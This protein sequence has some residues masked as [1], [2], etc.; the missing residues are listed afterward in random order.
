[1]ALPAVLDLAPPIS[2]VSREQ[3]MEGS[4]T[5]F[6]E[7]QPSFA[8]ASTPINVYSDVPMYDESTQTSDV[9][10]QVP[11]QSLIAAS[12]HDD[13]ETIIVTPLDHRSSIQSNSSP[14]AA[15]TSTVAPDEARGGGGKEDSE[16][17][18][19][20]ANVLKVSFLTEL[21]SQAARS[22]SPVIPQPSTPSITLTRL[23]PPL[24]TWDR[25]GR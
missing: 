1:M 6:N 8:V 23:Q 4:H 11:G 25:W 22:S 20:Y 2:D 21:R 14:R 5:I 13:Q 9:N 7:P 19:S 17:K 24:C 16:D 15:S 3:P 18:W 12:S 10:A